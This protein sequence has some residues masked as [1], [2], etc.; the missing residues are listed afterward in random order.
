[1]TKLGI[2]VAC[3]L[4]GS[5]LFMG[6]REIVK[7]IEAPM[8]PPSEEAQVLID[9]MAK[10]E[11]WNLHE[12]RINDTYLDCA[13]KNVRVKKF[14]DSTGLWQLNPQAE[15]KVFRKSDHWHLKAAW[16][17]LHYAIT[18]RAVLRLRDDN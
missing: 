5:G 11:L 17:E 10:V 9:L 4:V 7:E 14:G 1:M 12:H 13:T 8:P 18:S 2:Y 15:I 6:G 3:F 16:T